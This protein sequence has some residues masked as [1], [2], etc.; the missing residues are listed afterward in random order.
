[1]AMA[2]T[3]LMAEAPLPRLAHMSAKPNKISVSAISGAMRKDGTGCDGSP[4]GN[5]AWSMPKS[6]PITSWVTVTSP[7]RMRAKPISRATARMSS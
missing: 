5:N 2:R 6:R 7:S 4:A 3:W 1:M